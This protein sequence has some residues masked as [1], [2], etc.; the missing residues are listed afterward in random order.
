MSIVKKKF[1][2]KNDKPEKPKKMTNIEILSE[3]LKQGQSNYYSHTSEKDH[4][5]NRP[6]KRPETHQSI[7]SRANIVLK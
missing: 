1:M 4:G 6:I 2:N 5:I 7:R 3:I